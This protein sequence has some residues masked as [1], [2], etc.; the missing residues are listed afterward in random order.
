MNIRLSSVVS[1]F[2][3]TKRRLRTEEAV[4]VHKRRPI[5]VSAIATAERDQLKT[6]YRQAAESR[7]PF[8]YCVI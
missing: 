4:T 6:G 8:A 2:E 7:A 5:Y 3:Q 1:L